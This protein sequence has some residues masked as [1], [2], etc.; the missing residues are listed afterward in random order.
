MPL[1]DVR[2]HLVDSLDEVLAFREWLGSRDA[3]N[4]IGLDTE[5]TG[6]ER[7][8]RV[9]LVQIGGHVHGWSIPWDG[10][11]GAAADALR[12]YS[13][14]VVTHNGSYDLPKLKR[15]GLDV[16][17]RRIRDTMV[18][19]RVIEPHM[20]MALKN[21]T[22]RHVDADAAAAQGELAT[23]LNGR[24]G[25]TRTWATIPIDFPAYWQYAALDPVLTVH[26]H[27]VHWP[28][29]QAECPRAYDV[30]TEVLWTLE[31]MED[32]GAHVDVPYAREKYDEFTRYVEQAE[33]WIWDNYRVKAGSNAAVIGC[34]ESDGVV[35]DKLTRSGAK[36]LDKEVLA[37]CL[38]HPLARV[39][40]QRRQLQKLATTYLRHFIEEV[41][42]D[43]C[44][45]PQINSLGARTSRMSMS[46]PNLQNLPRKS[47]RNPAATVVRNSI[48]TRYGDEGTLLMCDFDQI[49][50]RGMAFVSGDRGLT[51]AFLGPDDFFVALAR[52]IFQDPTLEKK[53]PRRQITKNA[54]YSEIYGAGI[55]KFALTAGITYDRAAAVKQRWNELYPGTKAYARR[56][57]QEAYANYR[58]TGTAFIRS[59]FDNRRLVSEYSKVYA[60]V[61]YA[62]Q[63]MAATVFKTKILAL[64]AAGLDRY[65]VVPVHDEI[66]LDVPNSD[67]PDVVTTLRDIMNDPNTFAP[68]PITASVSH[69]KR[70]G[71]KQD[72]E[73]L[74]ELHL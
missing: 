41:D 12:R 74:G 10:W 14:P 28:V 68:I 31:K 8:A 52:E 51:E 18:M 3:E 27:D 25:G 35:F 40:L 29:V 60:L 70:W 53:D 33:K 17:R 11:W 26:L 73:D 49:E 5:T 43:D 34:L 58:D 59:P 63:Q 37:N 56:V 66:V 20:S 64:D 2:L 21:Q 19:S 50:M 7:D 57:E 55:S 38:D 69:G 45:H 1:D 48:T 47:E 67:V 46:G 4:V 39:V 72:L 32:H 36:A 13:G 65:M 71:Q 24:L 15:Q 22:A 62:I 9:R 6:L 54:G 61:N 23:A 42:G 30:E 44:I 16:E